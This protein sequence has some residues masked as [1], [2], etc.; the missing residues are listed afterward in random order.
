LYIFYRV[1]L[2]E[3]EDVLFRRVLQKFKVK[4]PQNTVFKYI[5]QQISRAEKHKNDIILKPT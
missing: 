4:L 1:Y 2:Q 3:F 5:Y